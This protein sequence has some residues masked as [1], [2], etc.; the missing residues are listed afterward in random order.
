M[1][2]VKDIIAELEQFAPPA[3]AE[4][5]DNVGLMVGDL[6]QRVTT[7]FVCLD[8]TS[9]NVRRATKWGADLIL[10]HHPL[11]FAPPKHLVEQEVTGSIVRN[12]IRHEISVYSAH[13]NLDHATG[14]MNDVLA[15]HLSLTQVRRFRDEECVDG[16]GNPID[17]IGRVGVL[18]VAMEMGDFA[19]LVRDALGCRSLRFV[20][21]PEDTVKTVAVCSGS[22]GDGIYAAYH[23]GADV[24]V[25]SDIRH[26]EAQLAFELGLNL[27]DAGHFETENTICRFMTEFLESRFP[28]LNVIP[29]DAKP[30]FQ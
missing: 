28:D 30:Y 26:H 7:V 22:G 4:P 25:T 13:T 15:K 23:A 27:I 11:L 18:P 10:S 2:K 21:T 3:L 17:N 19:E 20:G 12:L 29:S 1:L 9:D 5:W 14:G 24:F 8:V 16:A 6:E